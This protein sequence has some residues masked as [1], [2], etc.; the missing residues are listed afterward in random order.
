MT[1]LMRPLA[2]GAV[3]LACVASLTACNRDSSESATTVGY[4][5]YTVSNPP[6]FAGDAEGTRRRQ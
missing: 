5:T 2:A 1:N 4:S 3:S 6:F